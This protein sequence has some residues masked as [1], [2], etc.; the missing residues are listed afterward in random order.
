MLVT[1]NYKLS[2]D[3]VRF[4]LSGQDIWLLVADT[5]GINVWCAGGKALFS[6]ASIAEQIHKR[7]LARAVSH[8]RLILPQLGANGVNIRDLRKMTGFEV[9]FGPVRAEDI[10]IYLAHGANETMRS[11]TFTFWERAAVIPVELILGWKPLVGV[12]FIFLL[13]S[14]PGIDFDCISVWS[15]WKFMATATL[16]ALGSGMIAFPML[17]P[18]MPFRSFSLGGAGLGL[19]TALLLPWLHAEIPNTTIAA[20]ICWMMAASS[21]LALNFTGSTP[22]TSPSGVEKEMR[23]ALPVQAASAVLAMILF[24]WGNFHWSIR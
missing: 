16:L 4:A 11:V 18:R 2:F 23:Q 20:G 24:V 3:T 7:Q 21:Y 1:A 5:R 12:L 22:Y 13:L 14:L 9:E 19:A 17:L 10:P 6:A 8:R 15:R